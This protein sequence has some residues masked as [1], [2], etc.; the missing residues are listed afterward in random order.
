M[1]DGVLLVHHAANRGRLHPPS[2]LSGLVN[3]LAAGA[4]AVE[5]DVMPLADGDYALLHDARLE[6][7]TTG[8][9]PV[10]EQTASSLAGVQLRWRGEVAAERVALLSEV[11]KVVRREGGLEELQLDL[12]APIPPTHEQVASLL[13]IVQ[14]VR[15]VVRVTSTADWALWA[16]KALD[17]DLALGF[18]PL[19]YLD[20]PRSKDHSEPP[21]RAGAFGYLDDHPLALERWGS[22]ARYLELRAEALWRQAPPGCAWY[23]RGEML[24]RAWADGYDWIAW[25]HERGAVVDAWTLDADAPGDVELARR[26]IERGVDRITT[27]DPPALDEAL[28]GRCVY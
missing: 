18:D 5:V 6:G 12:K 14:P 24:D 17:A 25:L 11:V 26:L 15:D 19:E 1:S 9:G 27:N 2:S 7:Q 21:L 3:C 20:A 22:A 28:G 16:I 13:R 4:R 10:A 8:R 23:V